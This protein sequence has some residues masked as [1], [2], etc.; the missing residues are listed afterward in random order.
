MLLNIITF[1]VILK[2]IQFEML[3]IDKASHHS[4]IN[5]FHYHVILNHCPN[6][7]CDGHNCSNPV[8]VSLCYANPSSYHLSTVT[9]LT[10]VDLPH[11]KKIDTGVSTTVGAFSVIN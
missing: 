5:K 11:T 7:H 2:V 8:K 4:V 9:E 6:A 1:D 3:C 10:G